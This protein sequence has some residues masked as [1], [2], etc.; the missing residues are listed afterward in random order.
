MREGEGD[1]PPDGR[2]TAVRKSSCLFKGNYTDCNSPHG[3]KAP[4]GNIKR[5]KNPE[6]LVLRYYIFTDLNNRGDVLS[7]HILAV[8]NL[9]H[10]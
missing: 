4:K 3:S 6:Y 9:R 8:C 10:L 5:K 2:E 7:D 1:A